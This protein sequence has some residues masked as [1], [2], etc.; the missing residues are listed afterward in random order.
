MG[1]PPGAHGQVRRAQGARGA[2]DIAERS[3]RPVAG[4]IA[5]G[6]AR[7]RRRCVAPPRRR[8]AR[9]P[10][11]ARSTRRSPIN[12]VPKLT[13]AEVA[14]WPSRRWCRGRRGQ[15]ARPNWSCCPL[16]AARYVL[17]YRARVFNGSRTRRALP[18]RVNRRRRAQRDG[19]GR[20]H[21]QSHA[22]R[23]QPAIGRVRRGHVAAAAGNDGP[24]QRQR[25]PQAAQPLGG[26]R[27]AAVARWRAGP[28]RV[29]GRRVCR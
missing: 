21:R 19:A 20:R 23:L 10:P 22:D 7:R 15:A 27:P 29:D 18:R 16:P 25:K 2:R 13:R 14:G 24:R 12:P 6:R 17:A 28:A 5:Q 3:A 1:S 4:S 8:R 9:R 11:R 26:K